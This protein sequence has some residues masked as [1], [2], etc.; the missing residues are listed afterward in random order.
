MTG[1]LSENAEAI[2]LLTQPLHV[3]KR[4]SDDTAPLNASQY[5]HLSIRLHERDYA[6]ADLL[7]P[8]G[9]E[10]LKKCGL[11][12]YADDM[13]R[14]LDRGFLLSLALEQWRARAIWIVTRADSEYPKGFKR[15]FGV[16]A[17]PVLYGRGNKNLLGQGGLAIVGPSK[18]VAPSLLRYSFEVAGMA[19]QSDCKTLTG[20]IQGVGRAALAGTMNGGGKAVGVLGGELEK[21]VLDPYFIPGFASQK[22]VLFSPNDPATKSSIGGTIV[23]ARFLYALA[24]AA[25]VVDTK[26][27]AGATWKGVNEQLASR[28]GLTVFVRQLGMSQSL[29]SLWNNGAHEWPCP[30]TQAEFSALMTEVRKGSYAGLCTSSDEEPARG[31]SSVAGVEAQPPE[32]S[33][34]TSDNAGHESGIMGNLVPARTAPRER[35]LFS[36][37]S[38]DTASDPSHACTVAAESTARHKAGQTATVGHDVASPSVGR[39]PSTRAGDNT[40][41]QRGKPRQLRLPF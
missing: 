36:A 16:E 27:T 17:P 1:H 29:K 11:E 12:A 4:G 19:A 33:E 25:L 39:S 2:L 22:L 40:H 9:F 28:S 32:K 38:P 18:S 13:V 23:A 31:G 30:A 35:N 5:G 6:P 15:T 41:V 14:L 20:A 34:A 24:D 3:G 8:H 10:V 21:V 37:L 26:R 7:G